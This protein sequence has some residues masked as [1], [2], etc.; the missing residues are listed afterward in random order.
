VQVNELHKTFELMLTKR[1][2]AVPVR[3][4]SVYL[5]LFRHSSFLE[6]AL[7]PKIAKKINKNPLIVEVQSISKS[8]MP[9]RLKS[10]LLMLVVIGSMPIYIHL[11]SSKKR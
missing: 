3:K 6:C 7:Q 10:S 8:L 5:Q 4:L 9:T 2:K 11:Y 1:A